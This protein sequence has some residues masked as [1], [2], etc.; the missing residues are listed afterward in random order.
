MQLIPFSKCYFNN[1]M[2]VNKI[3]IYSPRKDKYDFCTSYEMGQISE[4]DYT[5]HMAY[6]NSAREEKQ[7]DKTKALKNEIYCF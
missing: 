1:Q 6:K 3:S 2:K 5:L 4:D 7:S